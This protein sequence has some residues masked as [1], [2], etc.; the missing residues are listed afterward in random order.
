MPWKVQHKDASNDL[1][2]VSKHGSMGACR[3]ICKLRICINLSPQP[4]SFRPIGILTHRPAVVKLSNPSVAV[5]QALTTSLGSQSTAFKCYHRP[6]AHHLSGAIQWSNNSPLCRSP[7][8]IYLHF[9]PH[10]LL[11]KLIVALGQ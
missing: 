2:L 7:Q 6:A 11:K 8:P 1:W 5:I 3:Q 9:Q 10:S 4:P